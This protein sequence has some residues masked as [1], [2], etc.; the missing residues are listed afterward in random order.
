MSNP[1]L[2]RSD[3]DKEDAREILALDVKEVSLVDRPAI[4]RKFLVVKRQ[5]DNMG[6]FDS[7]SGNATENTVIE[8]MEWQDYSDE[9]VEK[10]LPTDLRNAIGEVVSWMKKANAPGMP[11]EA[12]SLVTAFLGK[13]ASG[14]YP[15]PAQKSKADTDDKG[16]DSA[17]KQEKCPKCGAMMEADT[18]PSCGYTAKAADAKDKDK[19]KDKKEPN[20]EPKTKFEL[21]DDGTVL[22]DGVR[23]AKG[24][25]QFTA[26]RTSTIAS[27][28]KQALEML[29]D[30]DEATAKS[31]MEELAKG[32][33][34]ANLKWTSGTRAMD[35]TVKKALEDVVGPINETLTKINER[36]ENIEKSRPAPQSDDG[37]T[38]DDVT[39]KN[40]G[41][42][43][44]LPL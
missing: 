19:D 30:I 25:K 37:D 1:D 20:K 26:E 38:T 40:E 27:M 36:V 44:G 43:S 23:V 2:E 41:F 10:A 32:R 29:A 21:L 8:K 12:A 35:A 4:Q 42:W 15:S 13:V 28:A 11:K 39:K 7:E 18:C 6:A 31:I 34:P 5:E 24:G 9:I 17:N 16:N 14:K 33:L 3:L 22:V